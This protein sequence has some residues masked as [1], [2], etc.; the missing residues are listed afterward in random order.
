MSIQLKIDGF[1]DL[2]K[3]IEKAGGS[4]QGAITN[5]LEKSAAIMQTEL[6]TE[7]QK[8]GVDSG[9]ISRMPAPTIENDFGL[10]TARVG[11][12]K[13]A[14]NPDNLSDGYKVVFVNYGTPYRT[15]HGK[16]E[17]KTVKK[18][19]IQRAKRKAK[20]KI[21]K[22]QEKTLHDILKGL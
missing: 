13:G 5:C 22:Q 14:Y 20:P 18:G 6:T 15:K 21:K 17:G 1:N 4:I 2:I 8:A 11:Y 12:R 3:A 9:V 7:M 16:I 19:F 10:I